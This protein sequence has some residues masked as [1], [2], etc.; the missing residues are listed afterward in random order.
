MLTVIGS[1]AIR[2]NT[3]DVTIMFA[4]GVLGY[5]LKQME[6]DP[7]PVVLGLILGPL[8]ER[9]FVQSLLMGVG[10]SEAHPWLILFVRPICLILI[11]LSLLSA[12]WPL[13]RKALDRRKANALARDEETHGK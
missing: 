5:V 13:I 4:C 1:Y 6:F 3:A 12:A 2:N 11:A 9:G 7:G 8:A 10:V